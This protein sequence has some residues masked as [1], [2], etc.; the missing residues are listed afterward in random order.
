[1]HWIGFGIVCKQLTESMLL[2]GIVRRH[3]H[4]PL[5]SPGPKSL[6]YTLYGIMMTADAG[7]AQYLDYGFHHLAIY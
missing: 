2:L 6:C 5:P 4:V 1:M 3:G 7:L